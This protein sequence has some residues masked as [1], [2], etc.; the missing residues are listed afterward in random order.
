MP[1][2][3]YTWTFSCRGN[4]TVD[5]YAEVQDRCSE[6]DR[7][8]CGQLSGWTGPDGL[9]PWGAEGRRAE[10]IWLA[11]MNGEE[12]SALA[13]IVASNLGCGAW[14]GF[15]SSNGG[16]LETGDDLNDW[17]A[18]A[19][20][21]MMACESEAPVLTEGLIAYASYDLACEL[22][23]LR[24]WCPDLPYD[25]RLATDEREWIRR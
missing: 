23:H 9:P 19:A 18:V 3:Q 5:C 25:K 20:D 15:R 13:A 16:W 7:W 17:H 12:Q 21:F 22:A 24:G 1:C 10:L 4:A 6:E 8:E 2:G 14:E 11:S